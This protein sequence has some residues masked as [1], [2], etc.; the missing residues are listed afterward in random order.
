MHATVVLPARACQICGGLTP[1]KFTADSAVGLTGK[2]NL[3]PFVA[4]SSALRGSKV[5]CLRFNDHISALNSEHLSLERTE[6][7]EPRTDEADEIN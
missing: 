1:F 7:V 2:A 5:Q 3:K 6:S 4:K